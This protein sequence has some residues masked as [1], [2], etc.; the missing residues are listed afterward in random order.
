MDT[1]RTV[2]LV[3]HMAT[4]AAL[5]IA[6]VGLAVPQTRRA[7]ARAVVISA[8]IMGISGITLIGARVGLDLPII[9]AKMIVKIAVLVGIF[10]VAARLR[11]DRSGSTTPARKRVVGIV[12]MIAALV[13]ADTVVAIAWT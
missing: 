2:A 9:A 11:Q 3:V 4:L 7:A 6:I 8:A 1:L 12:L 5:A 10:I 13:A